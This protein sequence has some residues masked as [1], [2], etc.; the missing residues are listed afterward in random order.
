MFDFVRTHQRLMQFIL[1]LLIFPSFVFVGLQSYTN[2]QQGDDAVAKVAGQ[3]ISKA[4]FDEAQRRQT[5]QLRQML[6]GQFDPKMFDTP[7][8]RKNL[9]DSLIAQKALAAEAA[10]SNLLASDQ[11]VQQAILGMEG[12][13]TPDG[14]FDNDRYKSLLAMQGMTPVTFEAS[15]RR[16][17]A[18]QQVNAAI[19]NSAFAP[20]SVA[21]RISDISQQERE[22]QQLLFKSADFVPQVKVTDAQLQAYYDKNASQFAI[23]EHAAIEY[24]VLNAAAIESQIQV[25]EDDV[26]AYYEQNKKRYAV[27]EQRSASHILIAVKKNA[28][29]ADKDAARAKADKLLAQLRQTPGDFAKLA[30]ANSDDPGS[31]EK[32]GDLGFFGPGMMVKPFEEAAYKLKDG[33]ISGLVESDFGFHI[34]RLTGIKPGSLKSLE[35]VKSEITADI[36]KQQFAKKYSELAEV[37]TDTV[38]QADTLK[39]VADK[40]KLKI[41]TA[42]NLTRLP[43]PALGPNAPFNSQKF[44]TALFTN[45]V[46]KNKH[47]TVAVEVAPNTL[48]AGR[49]VEHKPASQRPLAEVKDG[50]RARVVQEEAAKLARLAGEAKLLALKAKD[51]AAGFGAAKVVSRAK[52]E[53][54]DGAALDA[55][56][57][58]DSSK[59]PAFAGAEL[60]Q[61]G[62]G[63]YRIV[64]VS[65]PAVTDAA[66]RQAEEQ[67]IA[68]IMAQQETAAY[69]ETLKQK[70]KVKLLKPVDAPKSESAE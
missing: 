29:A 57:K 50:I 30:K 16:D 22:V 10:R 15:V 49:V 26:K 31:G 64:K 70:A 7:Q 17:L 33:E 14:K 68:G 40:L 35:E 5:E 4:E 52:R 18:V 55:V 54:I 48:V 37:F 44:L 25:S 19:Q 32:G 69:V 1:L 42:A 34:I 58:A 12:L 60:P 2:S 43:N 65:Q 20:K 61:Q 27:D 11:A 47:N 23:P 28:S 38:E 21:A 13:T 3:S 24:V 6:G 56:M 9:L 59:L 53:G 63:V 45:D 36:R 46:L 62:Y 41:E 8:Q 51:D 39:P 67:Q 66:R